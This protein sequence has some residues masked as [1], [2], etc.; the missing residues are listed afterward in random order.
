MCVAGAADRATLIERRAPLCQIR[1]VRFTF[2]KRRGRIEIETNVMLA[3][4]AAEQMDGALGKGISAEAQEE[5]REMPIDFR[6]GVR[7]RVH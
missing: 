4:S 6:D 7:R 1:P 3:H 2:E 5:T